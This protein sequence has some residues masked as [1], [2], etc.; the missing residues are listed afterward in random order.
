MPSIPNRELECPFCAEL[1]EISPTTF[2]ERT[3]IKCPWCF[4]FLRLNVDGEFVNGAWRDRSTLVGY[5]SH[6]DEKI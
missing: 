3:K 1:I 6:W 2:A 5:R 4:E